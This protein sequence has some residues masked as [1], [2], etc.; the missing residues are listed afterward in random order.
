MA[1]RRS[2]VDTLPTVR[3]TSPV[4]PPPPLN[5]AN[6]SRTLLWS[7]V[8]SAMASMGSSLL[9]L[10]ESKVHAAIISA[11]TKQPS[12][13]AGLAAPRTP[14]FLQSTWSIAL[15]DLEVLGRAATR[16]C[17][18]RD[19]VHEHGGIDRLGQV[20]KEAG[21]HTTSLVLGT[22]VG[23]EGNRRQQPAERL[24]QPPDGGQ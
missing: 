7:L 23:T 2:G 4:R 20:A 18:V 6:S 17:D 24:L 12:R 9:R 14:P 22:N 5:F 15:F 16:R 19:G 21:G 13:P 11:A 8:S 3:R 1:R 10:S